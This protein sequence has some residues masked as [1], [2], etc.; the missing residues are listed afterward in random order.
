MAVTPTRMIPGSL[1]TSSWATYYTTPAQASTATAKQLVVCNTDVTA[2]YFS[3]AV[4]PVGQ[5]QELRYV[6]F[7]L[8]S[9]Q[10]NETKIFGM[11]DVMTPGYYIQAKSDVGSV[12]TITLSGMENL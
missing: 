2:R 8:V 10:A 3:Y 11:T 6:M 1:L 9:L 5:S 4:I 7:N 12:V